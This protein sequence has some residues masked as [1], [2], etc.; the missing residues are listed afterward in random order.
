MQQLPF[1]ITKSQNYVSQH[2]ETPVVLTLQSVMGPPTCSLE[3]TV[4]QRHLYYKHGQR[5]C[6]VATQNTLQSCLDGLPFDSRT[7]S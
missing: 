5:L 1:K 6:L 7:F 4:L 2:E 3:R